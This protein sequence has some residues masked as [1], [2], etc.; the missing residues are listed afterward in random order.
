[1]TRE[2]GGIQTE[3][4]SKSDSCVRSTIQAFHKLSS[5]LGKALLTMPERQYPANGFCVEKNRKYRLEYCID[6]GQPAIRYMAEL[7]RYHISLDSI[8]FCQYS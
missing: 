8:F 6:R 4:S 3:T 7:P 5:K 1:M 2:T